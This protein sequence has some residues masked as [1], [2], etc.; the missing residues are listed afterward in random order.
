M[1][2][3]MLKSLIEEIRTVSLDT[4]VNKN[5]RYATVDRLHNFRAGAELTNQTMAQTAWGYMTKHLVA[6]RDK[7]EADDFTDREDFKEKVQ[8]CINYLCLI[9]AIGNEVRRE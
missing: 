4:L 2:G 9:W 3:E 8:D 1:T 6:L 5:E 7:I